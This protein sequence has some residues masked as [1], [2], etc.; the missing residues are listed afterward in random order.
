[1][2]SNN[3]EKGKLFHIDMTEC[4]YTH[5][6][7][8]GVF[9][10]FYRL[11]ET[12]QAPLDISCTTIGEVP[13]YI[14]KNAMA[15]QNAYD[16]FTQ[17]LGLRDPLVSRYFNDAE[18]ID[19][20]IEDIPKQRGL[21]SGRTIDMHM[22]T[23]NIH[24]CQGK[25]IR[26][27]LHR[28]LIK[29]SA[30]P[31]HELFHVFQYGYAPFTN[32]WFMEGLA[33]W[34]QNLTHKRKMHPEKLPQT[35]EE[36][37]RLFKRAHDA[38]YFWRRLWTL[39][40]EKDIFFHTFL[41]NISDVAQLLEKE[42]RDVVEYWNK[43]RKQSN[44][45]NL[46]LL[47]SLYKTL[48]DLS[49]SEEI[50]T[51]L[52]T[53]L[54]TI[55][56]YIEQTCALYKKDPVQQ[57]LTVLSKIE[58][59]SVVEIDNCLLSHIYSPEDGI[60]HIDEIDISTLNASE[61]ET[62]CVVSKITGTLIISS[63]TISDLNGFNALEYLDTLMIKKMDSLVRISGFNSLGHL[64]NLSIQNNK[65]LVD[66]NGFKQLFKVSN[67]LSGTL[68]ITSNPKLKS[69]KFL[70]G[71]QK[72]GS[73]LYLHH[74]ALETLEGLDQLTQVG[75]SLSLS[76]NHLRSLEPLASLNKVNG[77]FGVAFNRLESLDGLDSLETVRVT[78][79]ND[80]Y[81]SLAIQGNPTLSNVTGLCGLKALE[82]H[83]I[84]HLDD[85]DQY[86]YKV[87]KESNFS[88]NSFEI[89]DSDGNSLMPSTLIED[90]KEK[91]RQPK[92]LFT[93]S[94]KNTIGNLPWIKPYLMPFDS[95]EKVIKYYKR[96][97]IDVI[98]PQIVSSENFLHKNKK[99]LEKHHIKYLVN[100]KK[101]ISTFVNKRKFYLFMMENGMD[102]YIPKLFKNKED[103]MYPAIVKAET[104]GNGRNMQIVN[105]AEELESSTIDG[106]ISEYIEGIY[107]Y[108]SNIIW[109]NGKIL[110][111]VT[112]QKTAKSEQYIQNLSS[113]IAVKRIETPFK[114]I[115]SEIIESVSETK[116]FT[117]CCFDYKIVNGVPKIFEV[118]A[119][120]GFTVWQHSDDLRPLL[121]IYLQK[122]IQRSS[123]EILK[124]PKMLFGH[125]WKKAAKACDW[126]ETF[127]MKPSTVEE[128]SKFCD[129]H[130]I[131]ILFGNNYGMQRWLLDHRSELYKKG[132]NF[133]VNE[134]DVLK[135]LVKK[136]RFSTWMTE[137]GFE[138]YLPQRYDSV[139]S[140]NFPCVVKPPSGGAGRGIYIAKKS[141]DIN[142]D[143]E[144][145][146]LEEYL[147]GTVEYATS[148][149]YKEGR[150]L[151]LK[152]YSKTVKKEPFILQQESKVDI[153]SS[154]TLYEKIFLEIV[155]ALCNGKGYCLCSFN[156]KV[157]DGVPKI[158]E[159]NPRTGYTLALHSKDFRQ[160][161][162]L[163][164]QE[165]EE[166]K[167]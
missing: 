49:L 10:F 8:R 163:Y 13:D 133:I 12:S 158:F 70:L 88:E 112:Y 91:I 48:I 59:E 81:R 71:L 156:Y 95:I 39:I 57:F 84:I 74:N 41:T 142:E 154:E 86:T 136:D 2:V 31:I 109:E 116:G 24:E 135:T 159:I 161:M 98:Y 141:S 167:K 149:F 17:R 16:I 117:Q 121:D 150:F 134:G 53:F 75:A 131:K 73:S 33:R 124:K 55:K 85:G 26:I 164:V 83:M 160:M 146:L 47:K 130:G 152:T 125:N 120:L 93:T 9:R 137:Q 45:N 80:D 40:D 29:G 90:W 32:A 102:S 148:I 43:L 3:G 115:F 89:Y 63:S 58:E 35:V 101:L 140:A 153:R 138:M 132:F 52:N 157:V 147:P 22:C 162:A 37:N 128:V 100:E 15:F 155:D 99:T 67:S 7:E 68:K 151:H 60:L 27:R 122:T 127:H 114:S 119:R 20:F 5:L 69:V 1:M 82:G 44:V 42:S 21:V 103:V 143:K 50:S 139:E 106:V 104:G 111:S 108:A 66:I 64:K 92:V 76:S 77:M 110:K 38:E 62:F 51:E 11:D 118:N 65:N 87:K 6:W 165:A 30:T 113:S 54:H 145:I 14:V 78:K 61:M 56:K 19:I 18:Y 144:N 129:E 126:I 94:W 25:S 46:L 4:P 96:N 28:D 123:V 36:L 34:S 97:G 79:W 72:T 107:E 23:E 166:G 105:N